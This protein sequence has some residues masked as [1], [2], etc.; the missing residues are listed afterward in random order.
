MAHFIPLRVQR[1]VALR[2]VHAS[3]P[4]ADWRPDMK[5]SYMLALDNYGTVPIVIQS[6]KVGYAA[7][8]LEPSTEL[9][10]IKSDSFRAFFRA[11]DSSPDRPLRPNIQ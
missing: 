5:K 4:V 9:S 3:D 7:G 11:D 8:L 1:A 6:F 10:A 2:R